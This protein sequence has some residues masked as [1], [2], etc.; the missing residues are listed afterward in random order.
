MQ[1]Q[2]LKN[3]PRISLWRL[4]RLPN[5]TSTSKLYS[6]IQLNSEEG[7]GRKAS[8]G[9]C[10]ELLL[11]RRSGRA[12][13]LTPLQ[14]E[15]AKICLNRFELHATL[16]WRAAERLLTVRNLADRRYNSW[17]TQEDFVHRL[18]LG[19]LVFFT[20]VARGFGGQGFSRTD[21]S[22]R[23]VIYWSL[24]LF[25]SQMLFLWAVLVED[26]CCWRIMIMSQRPGAWWECRWWSGWFVRV[27]SRLWKYEGLE[28]RFPP[29]LRDLEG[30]IW[31]WGTFCAHLSVR[32][33]DAQI[34]T[35][36]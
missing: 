26:K 29:K 31:N 8:G 21:L 4:Y 33:S 36:L 23:D 15:T 13:P 17:L 5:V 24:T 32:P 6:W 3:H 16:I 14:R 10:A 34:C 19:T 20:G 18:V 35:D 22:P 2:A 7:G 30:L 28:F 9:F 11:T 27:W 1:R 12:E 25:C